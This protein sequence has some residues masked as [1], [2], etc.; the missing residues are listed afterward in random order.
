M[1]KDKQLLVEINA[2]PAVVAAAETAKAKIQAAYVMAFQKP[3][4]ALSARD[5]IMEACKRKAFAKTARFTLN[6]GG[7]HADG[8]TIR[9]AETVLCAWGNVYTDIQAVY[10]D[11]NVRRLHVSV[12]DLETNTRFGREVQIAKTIERKSKK[13][14]EG[15]IIGERKNAKREVVYIL[16][17][18]AEE[19]QAKEAGIISR[20]V[21]NEGLRLIPADIK[22]DA[23]IAIRETVLKAAGDDPS[24]ELKTICDSFSSVGVKPTELEKFLGHSLNIISPAELVEL[25]KIYQAIK[26]E[27]ANWFDY[28]Q[29]A[30][31]EPEA[32]EKNKLYDKLVADFSPDVR[33]SLGL[34]IKH[35][36][37]QHNLAEERIKSGAVNDWDEFMVDF[38]KWEAAEVHK[39]RPKTD[40][41]PTPKTA[42]P[43][44]EKSMT[45]EQRAALYRIGGKSGIIAREIV[46]FCKWRASG[47]TMTT[48]EASALIEDIPAFEKVYN[49]YLK[50]QAG[51]TESDSEPCGFE[52]SK[53]I[54][55]IGTDKGM[56]KPE[57]TSMA[58]AFKKGLVMTSVEAEELIKDFDNIRE[59]FGRGINAT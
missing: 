49:E 30:K 41:K 43:K 24:Q 23:E 26:N 54:H 9:F 32:P 2:N 47:E 8:F 22:E 58:N 29:K 55:E 27:D 20:I 52:L 34:Y 50:Q 36:C 15:D 48:D 21:R 42:K 14:R 5:K 40:P 46:E 10:D 3:R 12:V 6:F 16:R 1:F 45:K 57:I 25:R 38:K 18:T 39:S 4:N 11:E 17:A 7:K 37:E 53:R 51:G 31:K 28:T 33:T 44:T 56:K 35:L 19:V 13:G 59:Q